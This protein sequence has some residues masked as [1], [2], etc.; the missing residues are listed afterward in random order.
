MPSSWG[1]WQSGEFVVPA[2][3]TLPEPMNP[4]YETVKMTRVQHPTPTVCVVTFSIPSTEA[5]L[6]EITSGYAAQD[7]GGG[8]PALCRLWRLGTNTTFQVQTH[9]SHRREFMLRLCPT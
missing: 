6:A 1:A 8:S 5:L 9:G 7:L 2:A 3:S 4:Q